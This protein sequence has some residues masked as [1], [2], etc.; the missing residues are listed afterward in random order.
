MNH[1]RTVTKVDVIYRARFLQ[2]LDRSINGRRI[3]LAP[4]HPARLHPESF[5]RQVIIVKLCQR[6]EDGPARPGQP[7]TGLAYLVDEDF[8]LEM[9]HLSPRR[10]ESSVTAPN[11][12]A[13]APESIDSFATSTASTKPTANPATTIAGAALIRVA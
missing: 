2:N 8:R 1:C 7:E 13:A 9:T 3:D 5:N 6:L 12:L 11:T 10:A 4:C